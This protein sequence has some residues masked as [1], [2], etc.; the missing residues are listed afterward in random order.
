MSKHELTTLLATIS[1][2]AEILKKEMPLLLEGHSV[3]V[4]AG[5]VSSR[6]SQKHFE[7]MQEMADSLVTQIKKI[8]QLTSEF[9]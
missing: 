7:Y 8:K 5:L 2:Q 9:C 6:F 1:M 4:N 3:A